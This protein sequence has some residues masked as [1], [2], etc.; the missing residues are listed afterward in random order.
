MHISEGVLSLPVLAGGY[1]L[2]SIGLGVG[3]RS[4]RDER[5]VRTAVFSS[6]FFVASLI[7]IPL[8]PSSVHLILNGLVGVILGWQVFCAIF[9]ALILQTILFQFGGLTTL[10]VNTFNMAFP[11]LLCYYLFR[12]GLTGRRNLTLILGFLSGFLG[13][14]LGGVCVGFSLFFSGEHFLN[15]AKL[16]FVAH[17]PLMFIEGIITAVILQFIRKVKPEILI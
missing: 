8:G 14:F 2:T 5:I 10:G 6:A 15:T 3:L 4:L 17:L 7:H 11:A 16:I 13:V 1:A 12:R 9:I